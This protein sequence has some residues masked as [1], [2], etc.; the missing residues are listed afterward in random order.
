MK[1]AGLAVLGVE[2]SGHMTTIKLRDHLRQRPACDQDSQ[3]VP[4]GE[5]RPPAE[6]TAKSAGV[7]RM[8]RRGAR[9]R[10]RVFGLKCAALSA[11]EFS[12]PR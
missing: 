7:E 2:A 6:L 4:D 5:A 10:R 3:P 1:A 12:S 8:V 9:R 11:Q